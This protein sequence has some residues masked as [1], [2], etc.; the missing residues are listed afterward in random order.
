[1]TEIIAQPLKKPELLAP[2]G[3]LE[4]FFAAMEKHRGRK[5]FLHCAANMRVSAFLGLYQ[6]IR[7]HRPMADAFALMNTIWDP[8]PVWESFISAMMAKYPGPES[9]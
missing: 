9:A 3:S 1:M 5:I 8:D 6:S 7:L 4:A 2:A